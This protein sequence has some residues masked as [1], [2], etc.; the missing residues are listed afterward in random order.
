LIADL[1][2][3][4]GPSG[5]PVITQILLRE[6]A[7]PGAAMMEAPDLTLTLNDH[8]FVSVRNRTPVVA[9]R[10]YPAGTHHP[11]GIL[12]ASGPGVARDDSRKLVWL[13]DIP[14]ILLYSLDLPVPEDFEGAV[15]RQLFTA[16]MWT[17]RPLRTG[18]ATRPIS[19]DADAQ[20]GPSEAERDKILEQM[21]ALGYLDA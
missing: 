11:D 17:K 18:Q 10:P 6:D 9:P 21:R 12:I 16:D 13:I 2:N 20:Q 4:R 1:R 14:A 15:P 8:G 7:F 19:R 5:E 3:L